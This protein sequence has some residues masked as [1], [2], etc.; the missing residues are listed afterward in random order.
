MSGKLCSARAP[1]AAGGRGRRPRGAGRPGLLAPS[2][3]LAPHETRSSGKSK[4]VP[5]R[6]ANGTGDF[7]CGF[8]V[9]SVRHRSGICEME[10]VRAAGPRPRPDRWP[11]PC[12]QAPGRA[13]GPA[14]RWHG[15][16]G[17]PT[18][19]AAGIPSQ[20]EMGARSLVRDARGERAVPASGH[21][22]GFFSIPR[23]PQ[24]RLPWGRVSDSVSL[25]LELWSPSVCLGRSVC[26]VSCVCPPARPSRPRLP[27]PSPVCLSVPPVHDAVC[28][29]ALHAAHAPRVVRPTC[30]SKRG[31]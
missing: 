21:T 18:T 12:A 11:P 26:H 23:F 15:P 28:P 10:G 2:R 27:S 20:P 14:C 9:S 4:N 13:G 30:L 7:T 19:R 31:A 22:Q 1:K 6:E 3:P 29:V 17:R 24:I 25:T 8:T 5:R 16:P